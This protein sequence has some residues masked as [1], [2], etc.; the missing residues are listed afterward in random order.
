MAVK[1]VVQLGIKFLDVQKIL[2]N[3][4][5][6]PAERDDNLKPFWLK[7]RVELGLGDTARPSPI[8]HGTLQWLSLCLWSPKLTSELSF[9]PQNLC[10]RLPQ[11]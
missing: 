10:P 5:N 3:R 2:Q 8:F 4:Y 9:T 1:Q 7:F 6:I 11:F